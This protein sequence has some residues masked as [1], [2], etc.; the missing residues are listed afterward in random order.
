[1]TSAG[2]VLSEARP[3]PGLRPF[4]SGD[5]GFFFG[6]TEQIYSLYRLCDRSRFVA[7]VGGS[8]SGKSS[9]VRAGLLP[10]LDRETKEKEAKGGGRRWLHRTLRPGSAPIDALTH[11]LAGLS[12]PDEPAIAVALKDRIDFDLRRSS[13]GVADALSKIGNLDDTSILLVVDQFEE[14]FRYGGA[15]RSPNRREP[16]H[17]EA[18]RFVQLLLEAAR[19]QPYDV[20]ILLTMR[21]DFIGDCARFQGLPEMVSACQFL[22]PSLTRSQLEEVIRRPIEEA[23][24]EIWPELVE[25]LLNDSAD[26]EDRLP[27][28]QHCLLRLWERRGDASA[29]DLPPASADHV[30]DGAAPPLPRR[31]IKTQ[32]YQAIGGVATALSQHAEEVFKSLEGLELAVEQIFRALSELDKDGRAT[33]RAIPLAQLVAETGESEL[34]VRRVLD[35]F[36]A[37]DCSFLLPSPSLVPNLAPDTT[38]DVGHEAFLR[39]WRRISGTPQGSQLT[40]TGRDEGWIVVEQR[41]G[42]RYRA[43]LSMFDSEMGARGLLALLFMRTRWWWARRRTEAWATRYGGQFEFVRRRLEGGLRWRWAAGTAALAVLAGIGT[44][45]VVLLYQR[46]A[47][48]SQHARQQLEMA[49]QRRENAIQ[50]HA[51]ET[52]FAT[53]VH[54]ASAFLDDIPNLLNKGALTVGGAKDLL[55]TAQDT[56]KNVSMGRN[57]PATTALVVKFKIQAFDVI[58]LVGDNK[59]AGDIAKEARDLEQPLFDAAPNDPDRLTLMYESSLRI[60][61][62]IADQNL[63]AQNLREALKEYE[64]TRTYA[65]QLASVLSDNAGARRMQAIIHQKI[66]DIRQAQENP[67]GAI[68]E[69]RAALEICEDL[70]KRQPAKS[71]WRQELATTLVRLSQPLIILREFDDAEKNLRESLSIRTD[72]L[73]QKPDDVVLQSHV[74]T[75]HITLA[76][77]LVQRNDLTTA[78]SEFDLGRHIRQDL[79]DKD[80]DNAVWKSYLA[81][82][83][84]DIGNVLMLQS[85]FQEALD[86]FNTAYKLRQQLVQKAPDSAPMRQNLADSDTAL[87]RALDK[88]ER[89]D[90]ALAKQRDALA[91]WLKLLGEEPGNIRILRNVFGSHLALGDMLAEQ[92]DT[93]GALAEFE[94]ARKLAQPLAD[95]VPSKLWGDNVTMAKDRIDTLR[96]TA[97]NAN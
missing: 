36:R 33:R 65:D 10:L 88:L 73:K 84:I 62:A 21:S 76:R 87:A 37:D 95:K 92:K 2:P 19:G 71:E 25:R 67:K 86:N 56:V 7:V 32:D 39:R 30:T 80:P 85:N 47:M 42:E 79:L 8:G 28:L 72:L 14:L 89:R 61:D 53:A 46:H 23:G 90:E 60:A 83:H 34:D 59:Q 91:I 58:Q 49:Q 93:A 5:S 20:R 55:R 11:V 69:Y 75:S 16:R 54:A 27:V 15:G 77:M 66:G 51:A 74:A 97:A 3:F 81:P 78:L 64:R 94:N 48:E 57:T 13:Y 1:M 45:G 63:G 35:R 44:M 6:R 12:Q 22:V 82:V 26:E 96:A 38:I 40:S 18:D 4:E 29:R 9:L 31:E 17:D 70:V 43:L 24:A 68:E 52:N 41:D 50:E